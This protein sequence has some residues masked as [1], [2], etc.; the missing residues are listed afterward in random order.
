MGYEEIAERTIPQVEAV[1]ARLGRH[2][3]LKIGVPLSEKDSE[4]VKPREEHTVEQGM[5]FAALFSGID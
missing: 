2:I 4:G 5:A 1:M 3:C